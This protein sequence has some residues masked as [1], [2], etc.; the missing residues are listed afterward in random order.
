MPVSFH[1]SR[2]L[3]ALTALLGTAVIAMA[4]GAL[5]M[6]I[7]LYSGAELRWLAPAIGLV[8]GWA[9]R[10]G[11]SRSRPAAALLA[12][13]AMVLASFYMLSL[14]GAMQISGMMRISLSQALRQSGAPMLL[15]IACMNLPS[16]VVPIL[17]GAVAALLGARPLS[18]SHPRAAK[19][20]ATHPRQAPVDD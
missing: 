13:L 19:L 12:V 18:V 7:A 5:W 4:A 6:L 20:Q 9:V 3:N 8:L 14:N 2:L 1:P 17:L 15:E 10:A 16:M 11:I